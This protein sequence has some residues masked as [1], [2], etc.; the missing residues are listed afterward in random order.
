MTTLITIDNENFWAWMDGEGPDAKDGLGG[1]IQMIADLMSAEHVTTAYHNGITPGYSDIMD[2]LGH[3]MP[4]WYFLEIQYCIKAYATFL[5]SII[6]SLSQ[7]VDQ[8]GYI[9]WLLY[10]EPGNP[11]YR[12]HVVHMFKVA[13]LC[14]KILTMEVLLSKTVHRQF[15]AKHFMKWCHDQ[16]IETDNWGRGT[17]EN[18]VRLSLFLAAIFHDFGYGYYFHEK[19]RSRL[20]KIYQWLLPG[21]D[22]S[23]MNSRGA[24]RMLYSLPSAFIN[25]YHGSLSPDSSKDVSQGFLA[26]FYRDCVR[27]NHSVASA[28][29]II[30]LAEYLRSS[31]AI[32]ESL[33]V[34]FQLAAEAAMIHDMTKAENW[35]HLQKRDHGH[36]IDSRDHDEFPLAILLIFADE[37]SE[38]SRRR[39]ETEISSNEE[40]IHRLLLP[41]Q[42]EGVKIEFSESLKRPWIRI[43]SKEGSKSFKEDLDKIKC[44]K[45]NRSNSSSFFEYTIK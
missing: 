40:I 24:Q 42:R 45:K 39:L 31:R 1:C 37:L 21:A 44:F 8:L 19:Y 41:D 4:R 29:F 35:A 3:G 7:N 33:Y 10:S 28:M 6:P 36:F 22:I 14:T 15:K 12:D 11:G 27:L 20:F 2:K 43:V 13:F 16:K 25:E 5:G 23:D 9:E 32:G 18:V 30:D 38:W 26:G 34:A 17:R